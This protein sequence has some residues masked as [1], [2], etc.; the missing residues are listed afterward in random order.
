MGQITVFRSDRLISAAQIQVVDED[1]LFYLNT[2][3]GNYEFGKRY[4]S[5][6]PLTVIWDIYRR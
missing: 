4:R 2:Y 1:H 3:S 6:C 5:L